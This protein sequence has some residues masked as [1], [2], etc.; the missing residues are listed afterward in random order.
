MTSAS[1]VDLVF[2]LR[3]TFW[4][5]LVL[6]KSFIS[7]LSLN[8]NNKKRPSR[9]PH[10]LTR[11]MNDGEWVINITRYIGDTYWWSSNLT[12]CKIYI[13]VCFTFYKIFITA[14]HW[15]A[16]WWHRAVTL[17][18]LSCVKHNSLVRC[19]WDMGSLPI[20]WLMKHSDWSVVL[21]HALIILRVCQNCAD[22]YGQRQPRWF[23]IHPCSTETYRTHCFSYI[24]TNTNCSDISNLVD[25]EDKRIG[26]GLL[27]QCL[28][29]QFL[30]VLA[31]FSSLQPTSE[32]WYASSE[33]VVATPY[34][35]SLIVW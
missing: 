34:L 31:L 29:C 30:S 14:C 10:D 28:P 16:V 4:K 2:S 23:Q 21:N 6:N 20:H 12:L 15:N 13:L 27:E 22:R 11:V 32:I 18:T 19:R 8:L 25:Y 17:V 24:A 9:Y 3:F 33:D 1:S 26:S 7:H 35:L 5:P